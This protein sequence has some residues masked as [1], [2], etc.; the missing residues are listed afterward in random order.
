M[1][2]RDLID[3][4]DIRQTKPDTIYIVPPAD[5]VHF[6]AVQVSTHRYV[7]AKYTGTTMGYAGPKEER[8]LVFETISKPMKFVEASKLAEHMTSLRCKRGK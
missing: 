1:D 7:V 4:K 8:S 3:A 6:V 2:K 5:N